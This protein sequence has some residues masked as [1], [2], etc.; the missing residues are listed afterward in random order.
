MQQSQQRI[1][2]Q[3]PFVRFINDHH[4]VARQ[5]RISVCRFLQQD[6][7]GHVFDLRL[8][9][10]LIIKAHRV[11][12]VWRAIWTGAF[13]YHA[14]RQRNGRQ[15]SRLGTNNRK[16]VLVPATFGQVLRNLRRF[17]RARLSDYHDTGKVFHG[18]QDLSTVF[19]NGEETSLL[20]QRGWGSQQACG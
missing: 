1:T 2:V 17:S 5:Q 7:I 9:C 20:I 6:A 18:V 8:R 12:D 10:C 13:L 4:A 14:L 19:V 3:C 15:S 11:S 16:S